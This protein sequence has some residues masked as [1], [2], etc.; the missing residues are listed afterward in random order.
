MYDNRL[1][2]LA[3]YEHDLLAGLVCTDSIFFFLRTLSESNLNFIKSVTNCFDQSKEKDRYRQTT[4]QSA[5]VGRNFM[6]KPTM[7]EIK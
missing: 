7:L 3:G 5:K 4:M 6:S 1:K 2:I